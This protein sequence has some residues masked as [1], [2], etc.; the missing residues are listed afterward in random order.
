MPRDIVYDTRTNIPGQGGGVVVTVK[1]I[2]TVCIIPRGTD[3]PGQ[4]GGVVGTVQKIQ[5]VSSIPRGTDI[6]GQGVINPGCFNLTTVRIRS[7][8]TG[9]GIAHAWQ[10]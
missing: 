5:T 4:G 1:K 8:Y 10:E 6:P 2:Q 9:S 7:I 3:I